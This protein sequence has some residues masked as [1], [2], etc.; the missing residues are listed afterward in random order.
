MNPDKTP[1]VLKKR[2]DAPKRVKFERIT[3]R[4]SSQEKEIIV[5]KAAALK[6]PLNKFVFQLCSGIQFF[7]PI[8]KE[9]R[10]EIKSI[11]SNLNQLTRFAHL[12]N[13][14]TEQIHEIIQLVKTS[15]TLKNLQ[16]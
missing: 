13:L 6:M 3:L 12:G 10:D 2:K 14:D 7:E 9:T 4:L 15:F 11:A 16:K 1:V 8:P 5:S